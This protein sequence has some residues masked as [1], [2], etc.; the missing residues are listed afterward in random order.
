M[1]DTIFLY[2]QVRQFYH[3]MG[4]HPSQMDQ[5]NPFTLRMCLFG[6]CMIVT[7]SSATVFFLFKANSLA[8]FAE[9]FTIS[10]A[11]LSGLVNFV[12][13]CWKINAIFK[14][15]EGTTKY[16]QKRVY[17][18]YKCN[19]YYHKNCFLNERIIKKPKLIS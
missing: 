15:I 9:S 4:I 5:N 13:T 1:A 14:K 12:I 3:T 11:T 19:I 6:L 2:R 7:W 16:I 10:T 17:Q 8:E 18:F